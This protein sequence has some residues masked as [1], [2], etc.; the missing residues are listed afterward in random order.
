MSQQED[1]QRL[2][3]LLGNQDR[4]MGQL[5]DLL[6][7]YQRNHAEM[8]V[9]HQK[10]RTPIQSKIPE[11]IRLNK[12]YNIT[13]ESISEDVS[14][15]NPSSS[16]LGYYLKFDEYYNDLIGGQSLWEFEKI[17]VLVDG[18]IMAYRFIDE[19][20][21]FNNY[22]LDDEDKNITDSFIIESL[23][24][25]SRVKQLTIKL[26]EIVDSQ[27]RVVLYKAE[28]NVLDVEILG[29]CVKESKNV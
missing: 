18:D 20:P 14:V 16:L 6:K 1:F 10:L 7:E 5:Q 28:P 11:E 25:C 22:D 21:M 29:F 17:M 8:V 3:Q 2:Y 9:L 26:I 24:T 23:S 19:S 15:V 4:I 27:L 12:L 13:D